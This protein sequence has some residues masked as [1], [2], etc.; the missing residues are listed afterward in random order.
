VLLREVDSDAVDCPAGKKPTAQSHQVKTRKAFKVRP[1]KRGNPSWRQSAHLSLVSRSFVHI[2]SRHSV[3]VM[4]SRAACH[5][6]HKQPSA[7]RSGTA[8][9]FASDLLPTN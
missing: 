3:R 5:R 9:D 8:L 1:K 6:P 7:K 4:V 2:G